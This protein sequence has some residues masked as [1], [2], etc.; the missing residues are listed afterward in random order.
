MEVMQNAGEER[1]WIAW[2]QLQ[3]KMG[4]EYKK[5]EAYW[6]QKPRIHWLKEGIKILSFSM[7][8]LCKEG[9]RI[10]LKNWQVIKGWSATLRAR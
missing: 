7:P 10:A 5:E 8:L 1:D 3:R 4:E 6:A 2:N 9:G